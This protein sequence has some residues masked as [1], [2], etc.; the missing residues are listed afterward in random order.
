MY[1]QRT[2]KSLGLESTPE[3]PGPEMATSASVELDKPKCRPLSW[4]NSSV[5][6]SKSAGPLHPEAEHELCDET[7]PDHEHMPNDKREHDA[8]SAVTASSTRPVESIAL[9]VSRALD[10]LVNKQVKKAK[11]GNKY[12][13]GSDTYVAALSKRRL[14]VDAETERVSQIMFGLGG[15]KIHCVEYVTLLSTNPDVKITLQYCL[16]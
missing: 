5:P 16:N 12:C 15:S 7:G 4:G 9:R 2:Q 6:I 1:F 14:F 3:Q 10:D 13:Q 11:K 8:P